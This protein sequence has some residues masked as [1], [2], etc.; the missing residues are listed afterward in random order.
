MV[1]WRHRGAAP[2]QG[3]GW[4]VHA[5]STTYSGATLVD[6]RRN[7]VCSRRG[8]ARTRRP[9]TGTSAFRCW[10]TGSPVGASPPAPGRRRTRCARARTRRRRF[11]SRATEIFGGTVE[12]S[13]P[14]EIGVLHRDHQSTDG[15]CV[16]ATWIKVPPDQVDRAIEF[17][18]TSV[19]PSLEDL[20]GFCSASLLDRPLVG[21]RRVVG[22]V[23]QPRRDGAQPGASEGTEEHADP[24]TRRRRPR[25]RRVRARARPSAGTRDGVIS[26]RD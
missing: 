18:K 15:A 11:A 24:R 3:G 25:R 17:Y 12:Q 6:R 20:E 14:W 2:T 26:G 4:I 19:L 7:C 1:R 21:A 16:R 13:K 10:S 8:H 23:R 22:D 9:W 5:R